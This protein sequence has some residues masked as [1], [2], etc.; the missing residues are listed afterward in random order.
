[1]ASLTRGPDAL[2]QTL[3]PEELNANAVRMQREALRLER[4]ENITT[5]EAKDRRADYVPLD[6]INRRV[7]Q[8][9][10]EENLA[11][12]GSNRGKLIGWTTVFEDL[13]DDGTAD[14]SFTVVNEGKLKGP[15]DP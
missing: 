12:R 15:L 1:M 14:P 9:G 2:S 7:D 11:A 3:S 8:A 5:K 10:T 13:Q 6:L 4:R